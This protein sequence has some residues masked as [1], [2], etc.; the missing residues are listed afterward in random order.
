MDGLGPWWTRHAH[1]LRLLEGSMCRL[2]SARCAFFGEIASANTTQQISKLPNKVSVGR[3]M[4]HV[5]WRRTV[6]F[7][8]N[9]TL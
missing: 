2:T 3:P 6:M 9:Y 1:A 4:D 8:V 5:T 7:G